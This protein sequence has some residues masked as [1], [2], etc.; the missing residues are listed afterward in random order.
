MKKLIIIISLLFSFHSAFSNISNLKLQ[1]ESKTF[2]SRS[3]VFVK[4]DVGS[5]K[6]PEN[7][8]NPQSE[9]ITIHFTRLKSKHPNPQAPLFYLSGGPGASCTWQAENPHYLER[10]LAFL[11]LGDVVLLDQ[12]GTGAGRDRVLYVWQKELPENILVDPTV[13]GQHFENMNQEALKTFKERG[14]DLNGYTT[15][16]NAKDMDVL[17]EALGYD[18]ISLM[19][20]SYGT[21][22]GQTYIKY[23]GAQVENAILVGVEGLNHTFKLPSTMSTQFRKIA[24]MSDAD[25]NVNKDV[26]DLLALYKKVLAKLKKEPIE[27][28]INSPLTNQPMKIKFGDYA[29]AMLLRYDI[30]DAS[31]IPVFP[32]FLY[33]IDQGD[34]SILK[35]F[36]QKRIGGLYGVQGMSSTMDQASGAT[37]DRI[38]RI[39]AEGKNNFFSDVINFSFGDSWPAPDLGDEFR[40]PLIS[41]VRTLFMSGTLDF[42]TPPYQAEE[43]RWG[44][45][46]SSHIIVDQAGHE[47]VLTHPEAVPTII[48]FLKGENVDNVALFYPKLEFIPVKGDTVELSHGSLRN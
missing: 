46:N 38:Q 23:Y 15:T 8:S 32:R 27:L 45:S 33:S 43:V 44:F 31:D 19:G 26:P 10:W 35:W 39:E 20:F 11:E 48:K 37:A 40:A 3:G 22:L 9:E 29:L 47:Q 25:S 6:V 30:G 2:K 14:V 5:L 18:K 42:N 1:I 17:R 13:A 24:L 4:A 7:R 41:D 21:H 28:E 34:Y 12:R 36:V 16:E